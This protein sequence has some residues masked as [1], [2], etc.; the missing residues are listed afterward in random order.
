MSD[1]YKIYQ[2]FDNV[3]FQ[4][5]EIVYTYDFGDNWEH[6]LTVTGRADP[7]DDFVCLGGSGHGVAEDVGS[8]RGWEQLKENYRTTNPSKEQRE[9]RSWYESMS[10]NS[11][12]SGL[13]GDRVHY[14]DCDRV[15]RLLMGVSKMS[16]KE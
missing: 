16:L 8:F 4:G 5:R 12:P 7:T 3:Q 10:S 2:L 6:Y 11:D 1:K 15:N 14:W 13:S 9:R